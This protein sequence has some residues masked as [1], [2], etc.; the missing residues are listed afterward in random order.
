MTYISLN[1]LF[2]VL[3]II[4]SLPIKNYDLNSYLIIGEKTAK[5]TNIY[6]NDFALLH[7]PYF[8]LFLYLEGITYLIKSIIN[9]LIFLK[10]VINLFDLGNGYLI[11]LLSHKNKKKFIFYLF[12]PISL[13]IFT[14]HGQFDAIP[15]FFLLLAI[16]YFIFKKKEFLSAFFYS[17]SIAFKTWPILFFIPFFIK[18]KKKKLFIFMIVFNLITILATYVNIFKA[19]YLTILKTIADYRSLFNYW[20]LGLLIKI[21]F[22]SNQSQPP[23]FLQKMLLY[24]FLVVFFSYSFKV[25][26]NQKKLTDSIFKLIIFFYSFT[27]GFAPQYFSWLTPFIFLRTLKKSCSFL[28]II[29]TI[30]LLFTYSE[31][32]FPDLNLLKINQLLSII[33]WSFFIKFW[34]T[35]KNT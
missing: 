31:W 7:H 13:L 15:I 10:V 16:Y 34:F 17:L 5:I 6:Q 12:N 29:T 25:S 22:F 30:Y 8:P 4:F 27:F 18:T 35:N 1:L 3:I 21:T 14:F 9:P 19:D 23:I 20:G 33:L 28:F 11:Y 26:L 24:F 32:I 2:R